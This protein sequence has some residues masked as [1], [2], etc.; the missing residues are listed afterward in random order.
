MLLWQNLHQNDGTEKDMESRQSVKGV[1]S[2]VP[3][4][5]LDK[6]G[7]LDLKVYSCNPAKWIVDVVWL[8]LVEWSKFP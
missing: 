3:M 4:N 6:A 7:A 2:M 8:N 5:G 1:T